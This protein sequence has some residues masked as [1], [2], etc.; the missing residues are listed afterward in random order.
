MWDVT[1]V[2]LVFIVIDIQNFSFLEAKVL[3]KTYLGS[4]FEYILD[5]KGNL[6]T[7]HLTNPRYKHIFNVGEEIDIVFA[8]KD[9]HLIKEE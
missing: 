8:K 6:I 5:Y 4:Y 2:S 3:R 7:A 9:I 1:S